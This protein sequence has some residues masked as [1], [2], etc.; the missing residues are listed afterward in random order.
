L[1]ALAVLAIVNVT[2]PLPPNVQR[3]LSPFPGTW[4]ERYV[5][6]ASN[7]SEWRYEMWRE[8]LF[9]DKWI[10]NKIIG[11]GLG[12]SRL[13]LEQMQS[14]EGIGAHKA[15]SGLNQQ[16]ESM[17]IQGSYHS[18][19]VQTIR[20]V[21]YL[22]LL[23]MLM[24]MTR[25]AIHAHQQIMRCRN[26]E[27]FPMMLFFGVP[28]ITYPIFFTFVFGTFDEGVAHIFIQSGLLDLI[29][30]NL[31]IPGY[32]KKNPEPYIFKNHLNNR[33]QRASA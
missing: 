4:E 7:S 12:F 33:S 17:M 31:P 19:P 29:R 8:A 1:M 14:M 16:Q 5:D 23:V 6:D 22:G 27:W 30:K 24:A 32:I 11:D 20:T 18:G 2:A 9:T 10:E 15:V 28:M 26:T 3:A 13:Q 21:G 25:I